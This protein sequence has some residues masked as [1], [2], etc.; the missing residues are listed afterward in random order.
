MSRKLGALLFA[1]I[2][3]FILGLVLDRVLGEL[4]KIGGELFSL[5]GLTIA[6]A[7]LVL[8]SLSLFVRSFI[9]GFVFWAGSVETW[10]AAGLWAL[11]GGLLVD[12]S[13]LSRSLASPLFLALDVAVR[14]AGSFAGAWYGAQTEHDPRVEN[15][16]AMIFR[17]L[18]GGRQ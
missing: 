16:L 9:M 11:G 8:G 6:I 7:A 3:S 15:F 10:R 5:G 1:F 4:L 12:A 13:D 17:M 2:F 18:P 14:A